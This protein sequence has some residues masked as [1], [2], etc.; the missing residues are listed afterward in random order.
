MRRGGGVYVLPVSKI[1]VATTVVSGYLE[2][3]DKTKKNIHN[4]SLT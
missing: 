3:Y 4:R 2:S 1:F